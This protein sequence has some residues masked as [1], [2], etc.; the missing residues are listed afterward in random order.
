MTDTLRA[1][2]VVEAI[3]RARTLDAACDA[4]TT[5]ALFRE[6]FDAVAIV[7]IDDLSHLQILARCDKQ[8]LFADALGQSIGESGA[9]AHALSLFHASVIDAPHPSVDSG[10]LW[11]L[12]LR[13][14]ARFVGALLGWSTAS[15]QSQRLT[16]SGQTV[17]A[18]ALK[19]AIRAHRPPRD[20]S[21]VITPRQAG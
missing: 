11:V 13:A 16:D 20:N 4:L 9:L 6:A 8:G 10:E 14:G 12:P 17:V 21:V 3:G 7:A 5:T 2:R 18:A 15:L 1:M 19:S